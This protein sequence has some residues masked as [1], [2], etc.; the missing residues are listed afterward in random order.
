MSRGKVETT[1]LFALKMECSKSK[2]A[3][4]TYS[5]NQVLNIKDIKDSEVK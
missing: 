5:C 2:K 1:T 4:G 3:I